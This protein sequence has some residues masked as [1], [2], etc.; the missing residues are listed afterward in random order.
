MD[1]ISLEAVKSA[2]TVEQAQ[3]LYIK[4]ISKDRKMAAD[5]QLAMSECLQRL[6]DKDNA[7]QFLLLS[8]HTRNMD[9]QMRAAE[10]FYNLDNQISGLRTLL[11]QLPDTLSPLVARLTNSFDNF[12]SSASRLSNS[13]VQ[14]STDLPSAA[15]KLDSSAQKMQNAADRISSRNY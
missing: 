10:V 6:G 1:F 14:A 3:E 15:N 12:E 7:M 11:V 13:L 9:N 8:G 4:A 2:S 5:Y